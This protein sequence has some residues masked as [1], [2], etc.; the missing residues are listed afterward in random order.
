[1]SPCRAGVGL[2][3]LIADS[4]ERTGRETNRLAAELSESLFKMDVGNNIRTRDNEMTACSYFQASRI[5][6]AQPDS[7][8]READ[9][10]LAIDNACLRAKRI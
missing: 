4:Q 2:S 3:C 9:H 1:M 8:Y 5:L 7:I 10:T 6:K